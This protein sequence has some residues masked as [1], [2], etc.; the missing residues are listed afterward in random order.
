[1]IVLLDHVF[2]R[3]SL[4]GDEQHVAKNAFLLQ[5]RNYGMDRMQNQNQRKISSNLNSILKT[6]AHKGTLVFLPTVPVLL[7]TLF[8]YSLYSYCRFS[9]LIFFF[10]Q[11]SL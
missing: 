6:L 1:M 7:T 9:G 11:G 8:F 10:V 3:Q 4:A 2:E 5:G